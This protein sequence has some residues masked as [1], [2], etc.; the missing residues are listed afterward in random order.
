MGRRLAA[1]RRAGQ[2][3]DR[4]VPKPDRVSGVAGRGPAAARPRSG[5]G[6]AAIRL[7]TRGAGSGHDRRMTTPPPAPAR[8]PRAAGRP[9]PRRAALLGLLALGVPSL[10]RAQAPAGPPGAGFP[11]RPIQLLVGFT[12]GG[13]IDLAARLAAPFLERQLGGGA[14]ITV[15]NRPGAGGTIMLNELAR[16]ARG[17]GHVAGFA[18]FPALVAALHD[19]NAA[20]Y[21]LDSFAYAG[22]LTDEPYTLFVGTGTPYRSLADLVAAARA[23]GPESIALAGAG[24]GLAS[25]PRMAMARFEQAAEAAGGGPLRF[26]WVPMQGAAQ[27]LQLVQGGHAAGAISTVSLTVKQHREGQVRILGLMA[28]ERFAGAPEIPTFREQGIDAA[29]GSARGIVLPAATPAPA[30]RRWQAA[31]AAV[32]ADPAFRALALRDNV[33]VRHLDPAAM[34]AM[35][36]AEDR[37]LAAEAQRL[38]ARAR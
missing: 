22:M 6:P 29:A 13:N 2:S 25:T 10:A 7:L 18:A 30:L 31:I 3:S 21:R 16:D 23:G 19:G 35:V 15:V 32:A 20:R 26:T 5:G 4:R 11:D 17:D 33:I 34:A 27:A 37:T 12:A 9:L 28:E 36:A 14:S 8:P 1:P 38:A 24:A